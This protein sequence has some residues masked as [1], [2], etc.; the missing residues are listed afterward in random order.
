MDIEINPVVKL[1][2]DLSMGFKQLPM[3]K[4]IKILMICSCLLCF[5]F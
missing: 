1:F 4:G 2:E 3:H 5:I